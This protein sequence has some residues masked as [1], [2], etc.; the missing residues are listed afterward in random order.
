MIGHEITAFYGLDH[1]QTLAIVLPAM[2]KY[3]RDR[4]A[5]KILQYAERI[6]GITDGKEDSRIDA[7]IEKTAGFFN[8]MGLA[9]KF[10]DLGIEPEGLKRIGERF[11]TRGK[12][13]GEHKDIGGKEVNEILELCM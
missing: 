12:K 10:S 2:M 1:V 6:W 4:K 5:A 7:A 13:V 3:K 11:D 8:S 9:T